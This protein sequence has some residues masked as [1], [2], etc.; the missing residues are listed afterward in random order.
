MRQ[1]YMDYAMSV[2][3]GRA[4]PDVR[5]GLKPVQ[6]RVLYAMLK[7]GLVSTKK[8]SKCAGVVGE[9]LKRYHPHGD[10]S[11]YDAL[12][13]LAQPWNLRYPLVDGQGNF[14]SIDGDPAAA[15]RYTECR[16]TSQSESLLTDIDKE[17][18]DF[19]P[20][21]DDSVMEP[22]VLPSL[23]PNL[24]VNGADGIAV[25][26][27]THIPPHNLTEVVKATIALIQN[28]E[29]TIT[30]LMEFIPGPDF[31]TGGIIYGRDAIIRAYKTGRGILKV[32]AKTHTET[33][34]RKSRE[35]QAIIVSEV[36]YQVNKARLI[37]KIA[38]LVND[39]SIDGISN[40]R[41]ES[42]REGM[43][44][45]IELKRDATDE[46]VLNQLLKMTP[47]K[48]SFGVINLAIVEGKPE[49]CTLKEFLENFV[50]HRRDVIS[51]RT[52][53][54]LKKAEKRMHI[55]EGFK[56]AL[57]NLDEVIELIKKSDS[58][59]IAKEALIKRYSLS[60]IQAQA[61]LELRLQK[62]TGMERLAIEK[63]H[64]ELSKEIAR[65][66]SILKDS[67][68]VDQ[69]ITTELD[70]VIERFGD[71]RRTL[72]EDGERE[73][74]DLLD[75]IEDEEMVVTVSHKGYVKRTSKTEYRSQKRGGKGAS[76]A[77]QKDDDFI[78]HLFVASTHD[79]LLIFTSMGRLY[80]LKVYQTPEAGKTARGRALVNLLNLKE[81][82]NI[83]TVLPVRDFSEDRFLI[84]SSKLGYVKKIK[85]SEFAKPRKGGV[86]ACNL[87]E[88]DDLIGVG[89]V[90]E[91][92]SILYATKS[93][94]AIRF[95][96]S[97]ARP[98]GRAARGVR[99]I[100]LKN[101]DLVVGMTI[102]VGDN[103]SE[104]SQ[105]LVTV[106]ENGFGKRTQ[107][108]DYRLQKRSGKGMI[109]IKT[110]SRNGSVVGVSN[111]NDDSGVMIITSSGKVILI[112]ASDI[113]VI[114]RN[115]KGVRLINLEEGETVLALAHISDQAS[116][117]NEE[118]E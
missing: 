56:I 105:T 81:G 17:T 42:D 41:D 110:D 31:P 32:A 99:A 94:M 23:W 8:T 18:V 74:V 98:M 62:L 90:T 39:K 68:K 85:L 92:D 101:E 25:G 104:L 46:V 83:T 49:V 106:T 66:N 109:D 16:M 75:L 3:I 35:V 58:P 84:M 1:S 51:R 13:R 117:D 100:S 89:I 72:I 47:L 24:L 20:N 67:A 7:E 15:Y 55:L 77:S 61:I 37:E 28:P 102:V 87:P 108:S 36:P 14:G 95:S 112:S 69:I 73:D 115:T 86:N 26:M 50:D 64:D 2:I 97:D 76:G 30:E 114:G 38:A 45:V 78:E 44:I 54:L 10:S 82:E 40:I 33:I 9:V 80:W 59:K 70:E 12:V 111:V 52:Q 116:E 63:E 113:S 88:E 71:E 103:E 5:D 65:L 107:L 34:K 60:E 27:A 57:A 6:R 19:S 22:V 96:E 11:V 79:Y 43:R 21:F 93:G 4:L 29:I 48:T 118:Q 91:G 53:F